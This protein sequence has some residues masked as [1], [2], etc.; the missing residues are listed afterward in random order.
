[1]CYDN[2]MEIKPERS[3][4]VKRILCLLLVVTMLLPAL[5]VF[6]AAETVTKTETVKMVEEI[7]DGVYT[8][9]EKTITQEYHKP[10]AAP[11][12]DPM[13]DGAAS[14][15]IEQNGNDYYFTTFADLKLLARGSYEPNSR[16]V[17]QGG[18]P[19]VISEDLT[20]P[21]ELNLDV[22]NGQ[23]VTI[24]K[25]VTFNA[26][27]YF[28]LQTLIVNG[29]ANIQYMQIYNKLDVNGTLNL[30]SGIRLYGDAVLEGESKINYQG[31]WQYIEYCY[32]VSNTTQIKNAVAKAKADTKARHKY[33]LNLNGNVTISASINVPANCQMS[34]FQATSTVNLESGCTLTVNNWLWL[35]GKMTVYGTLK[36]N[37]N[38]RVYKNLT[39]KSGSA[40][41][42]SGWIYVPCNIGEEPSDY[43]KGLDLSNFMMNEYTTETEHWWELRN[44]EGLTKLSSPVNL[45][46]G[47]LNDYWVWDKASGEYKQKNLTRAGGLSFQP[48]DGYADTNLI[49]FY[50]G[51]T[52]YGGTWGTGWGGNPADMPAW[53]S[54]IYF[55]LSDPTSGT[56]RFEVTPH[57]YE[58]TTHYDGDTVK[59][60]NFKYTRPSAKAGKPTN[61]KWDGLTLK[62]S[63]PSSNASRAGGYEVAIYYSATKNG[64]PKEVTTTWCY[65]SSNPA[66]MSLSSWLLNNYGKGYY[67]FKVRSLS[68]DITKY[69]NG[70]WTDLSAAKYLE[71]LNLKVTNRASDGKPSLSWNK[72][73][74]AVKYEIY[75]RSNDG[76]KPIKKVTGTSF[77]HTGATTGKK[78][79]YIVV[80]L[81]EDD[82]LTESVSASTTCD[83]PRPNVTASNVASSGKVKLSWKKIDGAAKYE[84]YRATSKTGKY[85]KLGTTTKLTY[86]DTNAAAGK[87][88][89][90][91]VKAIHSK[92]AANSAFSAVD[93][94]TAD[95]KQPTITLSNVA[96]SGKNKISWKAISGAAK[97]QV[98]F[99]TTGKDGSFKLLGTTTKLSY[100]H[101][102][103]VAGKTYYYKVKAIH[104]N[105]AANSAFSGAKNRTCDLPRP[106]VSASVTAKG[107]PKLTWEAVKNAE[108]YEVYCS[109]SK[110]GS[111]IKIKTTTSLSYTDKEASGGTFYYK[112]KAI[113]ANSAANSAFSAAVSVT[114]E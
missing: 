10:M 100:T 97:Y 43:I 20:M 8:T 33:I 38:I 17:Y 99:S 70:A 41:K 29:T 91:K 95:L 18:E 66:P 93:S 77:V 65:G 73:P 6:A 111:Y 42:G 64:E 27:G 106:D 112:V 107:Y 58:F 57:E 36:N 34:T 113:H 114:A 47:Q 21:Y 104:S 15:S 61:L 48:T 7:A 69:Q 3:I 22:S 68:S 109:T 39:F 55:I 11:E 37:S 54:E 53:C 52:Q 76:F 5:P 23:S 81:G 44:I 89:Y 45:T 30:A 90:Y 50:K 110:S 26:P 35:S 31:D 84:V 32:H 102:G 86:T 78:Y 98:Y 72:F 4:V 103:A 63:A 2:I 83:L 12:P 1:M 51:N 14:A 19:L 87:T 105:S 59:S 80:A 62:F 67:S 40:Y 101:S 24:A 94:R 13:L 108:K 28:W 85:T 92:S 88:Y 74:G 82:Y 71:P 9:V 96:S 25:G 60:G 16:A 49:R 79:E 56:Y 75:L 46:W